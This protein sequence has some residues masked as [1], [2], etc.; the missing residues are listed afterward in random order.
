[1]DSLINV[2]ASMIVRVFSIFLRCCCD[3]FF[4]KRVRVPCEFENRFTYLFI[5]YPL[6]VFRSRTL[7]QLL[8]RY[9]N[10]KRET[11]GKKIKENE[12]SFYKRAG[13]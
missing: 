12:M 11:V 7:P 9:T 10:E 4:R 1:M 2:H 3:T 8:T 13:P 6:Y 5:F